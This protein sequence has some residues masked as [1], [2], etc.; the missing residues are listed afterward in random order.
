[1]CAHA[2]RL[3]DVVGDNT[4]LQDAFLLAD[5][6]LRQGRAVPV[7][8]APLFQRAALGTM[9]EALMSLRAIVRC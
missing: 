3:L 7:P 9:A 4:P 1:M 6:G 2:G 5:D 8:R